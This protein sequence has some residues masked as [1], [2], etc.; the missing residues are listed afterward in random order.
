MLH[1]DRDL[2]MLDLM[3]LECENNIEMQTNIVGCH[4]FDFLENN[5][6][7]IRLRRSRTHELVKGISI[8]Y[9]IR[10]TKHIISSYR[11]DGSVVTF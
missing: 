11:I 10:H 2:N 1:F 9:G 3:S 5:F 8:M 4:M 7:L 6:C